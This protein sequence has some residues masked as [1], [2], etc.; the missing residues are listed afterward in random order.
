MPVAVTERA[1]LSGP[2]RRAAIALPG[3]RYDPL[4]DATR[5]VEDAKTTP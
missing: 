1:R 2:R 4:A 5:H 3:N